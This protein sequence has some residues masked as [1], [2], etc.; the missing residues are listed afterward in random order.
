MLKKHN[1]SIKHITCR[2]KCAA[3]VSTLPA[4]FQAAVNTLSDEA[5]M[6]IKFINL[7][8]NIAVA[9]ELIVNFRRKVEPHYHQSFYSGKGQQLCSLVLRKQR[10]DLG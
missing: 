5:D 10:P 8:L 9:K 4:Y 1:A 6:I 2:E 3:Q 7:F